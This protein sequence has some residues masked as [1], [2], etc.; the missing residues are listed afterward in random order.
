MARDVLPLEWPEPIPLAERIRNRGLHPV[1]N[2]PVDPDPERSCGNCALRRWIFDERTCTWHD[3]V[4]SVAFPCAHDSTRGVVAFYGAVNP[5]NYCDDVCCTADD[6][7]RDAGYR[8]WPW[9]DAVKMDMPACV[10]WRDLD[11][12]VIANT[13]AGDYYGG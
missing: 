9:P 4:C 13:L 5:E 10:R 11:A 12:E 6:K 3:T 1:T 2:L 8:R 7:G